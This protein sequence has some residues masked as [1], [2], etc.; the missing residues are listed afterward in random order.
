MI[1]AVLFDLDDT[2]YPQAAWLAGA[3]T[4]AAAAAPDGVDR[5]EL[6]LALRRIASEGSDRGRIVDRALAGIG[7]P[8]VDAGPLVTAFRR[9]A[10]GRLDPYPGVRKALSAIRGR[11]P[12]GLVTDGDV[13]AQRAKIKALQLTRAF[14]V[15]TF[16]DELGRERRKPHPAPFLAAAERLGVDAAT[17]LMVGDR[18]DKDARGARAAGLL[19]TVRVRTGEYA[20]LPDE[21]CLASFGSFA[22]AGEWVLSR[23][24]GRSRARGA[25]LHSTCG[26]SGAEAR[27]DE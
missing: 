24:R 22:A 6:L 9:H 18:P 14:D 11:V 1:D 7:A 12:I 20:A 15:V 3:W 27:H 5:A 16:S 21:D 26:S 19:G 10:P 13:G 23:L 17:C 25:Q 4:A 8:A 2:L